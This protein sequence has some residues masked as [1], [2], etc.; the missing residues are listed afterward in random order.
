MVTCVGG[1]LTVGDLNDPESDVSRLVADLPVQTLKP[2]QGTDP[3]VFYVGLDD[4]LARG[5]PP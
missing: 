5:V 2:E 4:R 1:A 3:M